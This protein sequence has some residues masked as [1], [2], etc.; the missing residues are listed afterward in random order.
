MNS[1]ALKLARELRRAGVTADIGDE[2]F[3]LKK[4]FEAAE[5]SGAKYI[6][7]VG[8]NEVA[9]SQFAVKELATGKQEQIPRTEL[10]A[11]LA[12]TN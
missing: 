6:V 9:S 11:Y 4:S 5:K 2:T 1:H 10:V 8:E 7:I 12:R 3:R